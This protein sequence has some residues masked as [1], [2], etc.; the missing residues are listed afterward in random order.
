MTLDY[1]NSR[2]EIKNEVWDRA[3]I[4]NYDNTINSVDCC[5]NNIYKD[6]NNNGENNKSKSYNNDNNR[7]LEMITIIIKVKVKLK[8]KI[9]ENIKE[10]TFYRC[11]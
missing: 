6:Y 4:N 10:K 5:V 7:E 2:V 8:V 9:K 11:E 1:N 3:E